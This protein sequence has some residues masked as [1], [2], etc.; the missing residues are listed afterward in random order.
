MATTSGAQSIWDKAHLAEVREHLN[1]GAY[2]T[3]Y[4]HLLKEA[5]DRMEQTP[6]SVM[7]KE[8]T[9]ASGGKHD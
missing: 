5:D 4:H 1:D 2:A 7:M 9:A 3:A 8:K 6:L